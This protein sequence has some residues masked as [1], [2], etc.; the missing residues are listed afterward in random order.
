MKQKIINVEQSEYWNEKSGPKWVKNE[1]AL[2]ERL[3]ILTDE[4]FSRAKI[5]ASDKVLDIGC[6]GGDTTFRV[7]KLLADAGHVVGADISNTLLN[8]A[9]VSY[10]HLTLPTTVSV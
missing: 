8:H 9:T 7:S 4:L 6:G 2:N 1:D 3:S 5:K 10:T